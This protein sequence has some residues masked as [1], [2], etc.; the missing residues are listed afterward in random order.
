MSISITVEKR[1]IVAIMDNFTTGYGDES[2]TAFFIAGHTLAG[3]GFLAGAL[4]LLALIYGKRPFQPLH[5]LLMN[6]AIADMTLDA[7]ILVGTGIHIYAGT[8]YEEL[9]VAYTIIEL[10][11]VSHLLPLF[12]TVAIVINQYVAVLA[13]LRYQT[14]VTK[15]KAFALIS[16]SWGL[17]FTVAVAL[18]IAAKPTHHF[19]TSVTC[20][21][22]HVCDNYFENYLAIRAPMFALIFVIFS[23]F[24]CSMLCLTYRVARKQLIASVSLADASEFNTTEG[25]KLHSEAPCQAPPLSARAVKQ[26]KRLST[27]IGLLVGTLIVFWTPGIL[28]ALFITWRHPGPVASESLLAHRISNLL[29]LLN[30]I[31][32]FVVYGLRLSEVQEG[33]FRIMSSLRRRNRPV[34]TSTHE[35]HA[36]HFTPKTTDRPS[37]CS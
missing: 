36:L 26:K 14:T 20:H 6:L 29:F 31:C 30:P 18:H 22:I 5:I 8:T 24:T 17:V 2:N 35:L 15:G 4:S 9:C 1:N 27:T 32:D 28:D 34:S 10:S 12:A 37:R 25:Y 3:V 11:Y 19:D 13:P 7:F 21:C 33:Y 23:I 16:V